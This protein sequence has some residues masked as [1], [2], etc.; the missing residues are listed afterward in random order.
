MPQAFRR[1][2]QHWL[3]PEQSR[4]P[5]KGGL[6]SPAHYTTPTAAALV[7]GKLTAQVVG[8]TPARTLARDFSKLPQGGEGYGEFGATECDGMEGGGES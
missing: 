3:R 6:D 7:A 1:H 8:L 4:S 2:S 5:G